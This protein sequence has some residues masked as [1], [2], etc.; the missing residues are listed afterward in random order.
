MA[1]DEKDD[2]KSRMGKLVDDEQE[3]KDLFRA[4]RRGVAQTR[5]VFHDG[6]WKRTFDAKIRNKK[7]G[8]REAESLATRSRKS[9][10]LQSRSTD[11]ALR[12]GRHKGRDDELLAKG[13]EDPSRVCHLI[14]LVDQSARNWNS[15][16][17]LHTT[18]ELPFE[19][20]LPRLI[21]IAEFEAERLK[22]SGR[23][24]AWAI[25]PPRKQWPGNKR[26]RD[27]R[28]IHLHVI[29]P[30][31]PVSQVDARWYVG[32][33]KYL[34]DRQAVRAWRAGLAEAANRQ[35]EA[36]GLSDAACPRWFPGTL[37]QLGLERPAKRKLSVRAALRDEPD[38]SHPHDQYSIIWN[39]ALEAGMN[40]E[41]NSFIRERKEQLARERIRD[42]LERGIA[43]LERQKTAADELSVQSYKQQL[44]AKVLDLPPLSDDD[45][46]EIELA[47][48]KLGKVLDPKWQWT[49]ESR[50][51]A[52]LVYAEFVRRERGPNWNFAPPLGSRRHLDVQEGRIYL[53]VRYEEQQRALRMGASPDKA[54]RTAGGTAIYVSKD[55]PK[56]VQ[57]R[58]LRDYPQHNDVYP[59]RVY[60]DVPGNRNV[61]AF[62]L[63]AAYD[64]RSVCLFAPEWLTEETRRQLLAQFPPLPPERRPPIHFDVARKRSGE[65]D[66]QEN[67][68]P[69]PAPPPAVPPQESRAAAA[70]RIAAEIRKTPPAERAALIKRLSAPNAPDKGPRPNAPTDPSRNLPE[71][72]VSSTEKTPSQ[73][74]PQNSPQSP[75]PSR[76]STPPSDGKLGTAHQIAPANAASNSLTSAEPFS[77]AEG[78]ANAAKSAVQRMDP[79][80][81]LAR[82]K[83]T[84]TQLAALQA[85]RAR[86]LPT[87]DEIL[88]KQSL[89]RGESVLR[90]EISRR[91]ISSLNRN[92]AEESK[93]R[94]TRPSRETAQHQSPRTHERRDQAP[95]R[96]RRH[97][98]QRGGDHP[99]RRRAA[100]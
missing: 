100:P 25:H 52:F 27:N 48:W 82:Y 37:R 81:L 6:T 95:H 86:R 53:D 54:L 38:L 76:I 93:C 3:G 91:G 51:R 10:A 98:P 34:A 5:I 7:C 17:A 77:V 50:D 84:K 31:R 68:G 55:A 2:E 49:K 9:L 65:G 61:E 19:L 4:G 79:A 57:A 18:I 11:Y 72:A 83:A 47:H 29:A 39:G 44:A 16:T 66:A 36:E 8:R 90:N 12:E 20:P 22:Q 70:W 96:G 64:P 88:K 60:I 92:E 78:Q 71:A 87:A 94:R 42:N 63:G 35:M 33:G 1:A 67:S 45:I 62:D 74:V 75:P 23:P 15:A 85:L 21:K 89:Q 30:A 14:E 43:S 41:E 59:R 80:S 46:A 40:P 56:A 97:L 99:S 69:T 24:A 26:R 32:K 58:L 28:N 73:L 13:G